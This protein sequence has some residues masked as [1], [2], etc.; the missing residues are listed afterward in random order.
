MQTSARALTLSKH[1]LEFTNLR[2]M[3]AISRQ[4]WTQLLLEPTSGF[5]TDMGPYSTPA[6]A[7]TDDT[8]SGHNLAACG[9]EFCSPA[10][11]QDRDLYSYWVSE[12]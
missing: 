3:F 2:S 5:Y 10:A 7:G 12:A 8:E 4:C 9:R 11:E 1:H 6:F